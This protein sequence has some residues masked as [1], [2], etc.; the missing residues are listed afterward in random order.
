MP[1]PFFRRF[2]HDLGI[3]LGTANTL[4]YMRGRGIVIN[5]PSVVAQ[6]VKTGQVLAVGDEAKRM[7]GKAPG[8]IQVVRPL[9]DGIISDFEVTERMLKYFMMKVQRGFSLSPKPRVVIAIPLEV[10]EVERKAVEDAVLSAGAR[11]VFLVEEPMAAAIGARLPIG[12]PQGNLIVDIGGGTTD[13][14]VIALGGMVQSRSLKVAGDEM[15]HEIR[16]YTRLKF[17][18]LIGERTAEEIKTKI[19]SA[20]ALAE[21]LTYL[22]RG[23]DLVTGL[24]R[25]VE[26]HDDE[27]RDAL[28]YPLGIILEN[29][30][31]V[32]ELTPP[33]LIADVYEKG[34]VLTGGGALLKGI[35]RRI[36]QETGVPVRV[37]DDPLTS[38]ALGT[39]VIIEDLDHLKD[40]LIQPTNVT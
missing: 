14:A 9:V 18:L 21:P 5:E 20:S 3:D 8:T 13:I 39:G 40:L 26:A 17:N 22:I 12:E 38:V 28:K 32:M 19:G 7:L 30:L 16:E 25:Q 6:Q 2:S 23:R 35:D 1:F 33:E 37:T 27:I 15:D 36:A 29:I 10:T 34:I 31:T 24:P 4:V 11:E